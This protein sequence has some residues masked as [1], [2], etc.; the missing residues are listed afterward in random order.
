[1]VLIIFLRSCASV[2]AR[3]EADTLRVSFEVHFRSLNAF[4]FHFFFPNKKYFS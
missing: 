4:D 1:M 2:V 3:V